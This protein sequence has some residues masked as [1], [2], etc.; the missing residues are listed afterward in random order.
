MARSSDRANYRNLLRFYRFAVPHWKMV[1]VAAVAT[2]AYAASTGAG[3]MMVAPLMRALGAGDGGPTVAF[4][5][6]PQQPEAM[7]P[8]PEGLEPANPLK[9]YRARLVRWVTSR[10]PVQKVIAWLSP[11]S[12]PKKVAFLIACVIGPLVVISRFAQVYAHRRVVWSIMVDLRMAFFERLSQF[13]LGYF[14]RQRTGELLSR[15][16]NDINST[17]MALKVLFEKILSEPLRLVAFFCVALYSSWQ[18]T[19]LAHV[20]FP[21]VLYLL[22]RFGRRI[23]R[24]GAKNL[25][26]LADVTDAV[27]QMLSGIRV[28]KAFHMEGAEIEGFRE[29]N[30]DQL[31][32]ALKL[33]RYR[34]LAESLPEYFYLL[35]AALIVLVGARLVSQGDL[36][37]PRIVQCMA[38]LGL[39]AGPTRRIIKA[40]SDLQSSMPG[41]NRLFELLDTRPAIEDADEAVDIDGVRQGI[42]FRDVWFAYDREPVL[43]GINLEAPAGHIYAIV[44]ETGAGKSTM[45]DLIPRFYDV[46]SGAVLIDGIDVRRITRSSLMKQIAIVSQHPFLFNRSIAENI[47]YGKP[48][49][50]DEE[51]MEAARAANIHEFIESL[52]QGYQTNVGETGGRLSGGQRQ[53]VTI[54]RAIL[55]NAPIL[56]LDEATSSLDA[57]SEMLVQR[58]LNNLMKNRTTFVIAHRLSTVR[59]ADRIIVLKDGRIIEQGTH[60]ELLRKG[61]EYERLYRIQFADQN[62]TI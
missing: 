15:L 35:P 30:R 1:A 50:T 33:V 12:D 22:T 9:S 39:M 57:Q 34:A 41:V 26:K 25:E 31:R 20:T 5:P 43:K 45:L 46:T 17:Q 60:E 24:Y 61:G 48:D 2:V 7:P 32:R 3:V 14:S 19:L 49:A 6:A 56:I 40:Y 13:S 58:A 44:G 62:G 51:V 42:T 38:A 18:L 11:G 23:R 37:A 36:T 47:R 27:T 54:A 8:A 4:E 55:K 52:P 29:R 53:C 21:P 16:T 59:H 28:V 10:P